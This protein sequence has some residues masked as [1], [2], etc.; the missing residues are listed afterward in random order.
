M[1]GRKFTAILLVAVAAAFT[2]GFGIK[3]ITKEIAP[4]TEKCDDKK[5]KSKCKNEEYLK[6]GAKII[7][8]TVAAKALYD[9]V[10]EYTALNVKGDHE[11]I[12]LYLKE[13]KSLPKKAAIL[14]YKASMSPGNVVK[15]GKPLK[16]N[17]S[18]TVIPGKKDKKVDISET[19]EIYDNEDKSK[20]IKSLTKPVNTDTQKGGSFENN[21]SFTLPVGMP[22]GIYPVRTAITANGTTVPAKPDEMQVVLHILPNG[23]HQL[24][25]ISR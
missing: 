22:Q 15:V 12:D 24:A 8:V 19:I 18:V 11:V 21:F 13:H 23:Q 16:I 9:V 10:V 6:S 17:T 20:L 7:A 14:D 1:L 2:T 5:N 3:D 25:Y 4:D